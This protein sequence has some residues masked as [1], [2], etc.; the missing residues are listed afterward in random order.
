MLDNFG[1]KNME[2]LEFFFKMLLRDIKF[3]IEFRY[4]D[5]FNDVVV[6][7]ELYDILEWNEIFNVIVD[8]VGRRDLLYMKM[9]IIIVFI[10]YNGVN[11]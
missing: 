6:V 3:V 11:Y 10:C 8:I 7:N 4:I 1:F 5:W 2:R 9:M